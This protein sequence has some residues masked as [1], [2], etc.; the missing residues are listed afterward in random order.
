MLLLHNYILFI[1]YLIPY[2][3]CI[4]RGFFK[5]SSN[6]YNEWNPSTQLSS[7]SIGS[8]ISLPYSS[9]TNS[10]AY[11][12]CHTIPPNMT[13]CKSVGYSRMVLPNFLHHESLR[14]AIQQANVW[15]ALVNTD[16]HPDIQRFLCSLYAPVCLK[17]HQEAKIPPCW[18][19]CNQVRNAC[20]PRMKLF[21]FDWPDIVH[22]QQFPR[23]AE[24]MCIPPQEKSTAVTCVPCE[25]AITLE[26]IA[27]SYC[28]ADV[29]LKAS[30]KDMIL[31]P[32]QASIILNLT[33]RTLALKLIRNDGTQLSNIDQYRR[34]RNS[35]RTKRRRRR[36]RNHLNNHDNE[37]DPIY[38]LRTRRELKVSKQNQYKSKLINV[39]EG[40]HHHHHHHHQRIE[41]KTKIKR[42]RQPRNSQLHDL[43]GINELILSCS[44]CN[45]LLP[46]INGHFTSSL[47]NQ[48]WLIMG[49]RIQDSNTK[50]YTN[51]LQVTFLGL[52]NRESI[53]F[54]QSLNAIRKESASHLCNKNQ[55][56]LS[57]LV[58]PQTIQNHHQHLGR[59]LKILRSAPSEL[60]DSPNYNEF[61]KPLSNLNLKTKLNNHHN[62][63]YPSHLST[64][65]NTTNNDFSSHLNLEINNAQTTYLNEI[66]QLQRQ[67]QRPQQQRPHKSRFRERRKK[68]K[69]STNKVL[70]KSNS[71]NQ[72][73]T[74]LYRYQ[75]PINPYSD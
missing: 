23:L 66:H 2:I 74:N 33:P 8:S 40:V 60:S 38:Q 72:Y 13:L 31:Q 42:H 21:G 30:V 49:R 11:W 41:S 37:L 73:D 47:S 59:P 29:V 18:E 6:S 71:Q 3:Y 43:D 27:S 58:Q 12:N 9:D 32:N 64:N 46:F 26:N 75:S 52:W 57:N 4:G 63:N 35:R 68:W 65:Q 28:M 10:Y 39:N 19:L 20:L 44:S 14:E 7:S 55:A 62:Y 25:Q 45:P 70:L 61:N 36:R 48:K 69:S 53:E 17:S 34:K 56:S 51:Q 67:Q 22:C 15:I 5:L 1:L 24:S 54:R 50:K 16:C